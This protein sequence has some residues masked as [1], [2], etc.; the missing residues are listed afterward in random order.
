LSIRVLVVGV[1]VDGQLN[2]RLLVCSNTFSDALVARFEESLFHSLD[3]TELNDRG[4]Q[5]Q[6]RSHWLVFSARVDRPVG[7]SGVTGSMDQS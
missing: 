2:Y 3:A 7:L 1:S 6:R 4:S 5:G